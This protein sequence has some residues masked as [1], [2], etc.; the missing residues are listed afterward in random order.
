MHLEPAHSIGKL[1]FRRWY[2]RQ[3]V[4]AHMW[5]VSALLCLIV[6][7]VALEHFTIRDFGLKSALMLAILLAGGWTCWYASR[8]YLLMLIGTQR[9]A[10]HSTCAACRAYGLFDVT[11]DAPLR[12]RCRKCSNEWQMSE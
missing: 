7:L 5:L 3:L 11:R 12:V 4:E 1:G 6:A 10:E 8:R 9:I 2:S